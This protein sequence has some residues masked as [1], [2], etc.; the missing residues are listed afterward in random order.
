M[1]Q[2]YRPILSIF[3]ALSKNRNPSRQVRRDLII[4]LRERVLFCCYYK[5]NWLLT[6]SFDIT[7]V[8]DSRHP[9]WSLL[10]YFDRLFFHTVAVACQGLYITYF[11][12]FINDELHS[13]SISSF[14]CTI[15]N[16]YIRIKVSF[17]IFAPLSFATFKACLYFDFLKN[18]VFIFI[19]LF[20]Y[21]LFAF[22]NY[23]RS[24]TFI[25]YTFLTF[26]IDLRF[27]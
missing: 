7:T 24:K 17:K 20:F 12:F 19:F 23:S 13:N 21:H 3:P 9:I 4:C 18:L 16:R 2:L 6:I 10:D 1:L 15:F 14:S 27:F 25:F 11:S 26:H 5:S 8:L 22:I